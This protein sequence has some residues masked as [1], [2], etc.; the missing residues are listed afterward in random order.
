MF[1]TKN[2]VV[3]CLEKHAQLNFVN[4]L[5]LYYKKPHHR[6][7]RKLKDWG[8]KLK[9]RIQYRNLNFSPLIDEIIK[10]DKDPELYKAMLK[11]SW[12]IK[13]QAP[14]HLSTS[15]QWEKIFNS[16]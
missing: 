9:M 16:L 14:K 2:G 4:I 8:K 15:G 13:N 7:E 1:E 10:I 12:F 5:P 3:T 6:I 11:K